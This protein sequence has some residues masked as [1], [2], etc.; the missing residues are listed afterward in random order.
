MITYLLHLPLDLGEEVDKL[1]VSRQQQAAGG[2]ATQVE[3]GVEQLELHHG[4]RARVAR[5]QVSELPQDV[6]AHLHHVL[7]TRG[8]LKGLSGEEGIENN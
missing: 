8:G 3:L 5:N 2:H 6:T 4:R 1:D 7:V